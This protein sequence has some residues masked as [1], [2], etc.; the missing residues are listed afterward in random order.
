[1]I[2]TR[3][4]P[5]PTGYL[6]VGG[7]HTALYSYL[8]AKQA[9]G[10]FLLR[11]EDTDRERFVADGMM[12]IVKSLAWVGVVPDEGV[13]LDDATIDEPVIVQKGPFGSYIQSERLP[14]YK[15]HAELLLKNGK[16]YYCFCTSECLTELRATQE[17]NKLPTGYDGHCAEIAPAE[18]AKRV[19]AGERAVV[20]VKMPK[21]G[22]TEIVDLV[23]GPVS[24]KNE[25]Q[26]DFVGLK[27]DGFP[28]YHLASVVDDHHMQITH[29]IRGEEWLSSLPKHI[30]LYHAF[31]WEIPQFAHLSLLLNPDKS[32]LSKRQGDVAVGDYQAKGYVAEALINF[33]ALLG[34]NPGDERE[35][36]S[37]DQLVKEFSLA[38]VSKAGAVFNVEKLNWFNKEYIKAMSPSAFAEACLPWFFE[39]KLVS[40]KEWLDD[41]YRAWFERALELEKERVTTLAE[42]V[43]AIGFV[44]ALPDFT[45][46]QLVWRKGTLDEVKKILPELRIFLQTQAMSDK[47]AFEGAVKEWITQNNYQTGSVLWPLRVALSGQEKSPGPFEI[48]EVLGAKET[49]RRLD[50][51]LAKLA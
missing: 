46:E 22:V 28:T 29:V 9:S 11:V 25:L 43:P 4:A 32:K 13:M 33:V 16:A 3:F 30:A 14:L 38:K 2:R 7:L 39:A 35:I 26:D 27:S 21:S 15:E 19:A 45:K 51:A 6:H 49:L 1:M 18:A 31:G 20:R 42:V 36:F 8:I 24:F 48:A 41:T 12:N 5:S 17:K 23:R 50:L 47:V 44:F 34:W 40:E 10:A 37:L